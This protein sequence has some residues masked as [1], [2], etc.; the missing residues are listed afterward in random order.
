M[1]TNSLSLVKLLVQALRTRNV[2]CYI[3][4]FVISDLC[5]WSFYYVTRV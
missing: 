4:C 5:I 1:I 3:M 2:I